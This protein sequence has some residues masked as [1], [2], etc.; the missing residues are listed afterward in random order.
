M[1]RLTMAFALS[2]VVSGVTFAQD[3][4][5]SSRPNFPPLGHPAGTFG[6]PVT[7]EEA[8][9][10]ADVAKQPDAF[11]GR[12]I[13]LEGGIDDV[14]QKKGCWMVI[15]D[16]EMT[17]RVLVKDHAFA[18]PMDGKG[19]A[20]LVEGTLEAKELSEANVAHLKQDGDDTLEGDGPRKEY[21][22]H[23]TAVELSANS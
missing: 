8:T 7:V 16:G 19:K 5:P 21:F 22:L 3:S 12:T 9:S 14:C 11:E 20:A 13:R 23:A 4:R 2:L 6:G 1:S 17:A 15:K 18:I 10:L